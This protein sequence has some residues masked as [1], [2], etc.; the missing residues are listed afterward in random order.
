MAIDLSKITDTDLFACTGEDGTTYSVTGAQFKELFASPIPW[1]GHPGG[2]W[3]VKNARSGQNPDWDQLV[4]FY[5][6]PYQAYTVDGTD[7]GFISGFSTG[8]E[9]VFVAGADATGL[10]SGGSSYNGWQ[11]ETAA[12]DF[13]E[14][15]DTSNVTDMSFMFY[16]L[17]AF[18]GTL[19][20]NWDT[21]N[22]TNMKSMFY[23]AGIFNQDIDGWNTS[24]VTIM[25]DM[26]R[27]TT[28]FNRDIGGWNTSSVT[29]MCNMF[30]SAK[31]FNRDIGR[32][33]T[34]NVTNMSR[35]FFYAPRFNRDIGTKQVTV[36][37]TTYTAWNTSNVTDM[38][39]LFYDAE[40]FN[41]DIGGWDT[42]NVT[43]M[44]DMFRRSPKFDQDIGT[45]QVTVNG[46]TYTAWNTS[47]VWD[48][49]YMFIDAK[50]F[51]QDIGG[52][53]VSN[54]TDWS[55][56]FTNAKAFN[57]DLSGWCVTNF[58]SEPHRFS[59]R[60]FDWTEPKPC[61]GHCPRG[62]NNLGLDPCP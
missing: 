62:E 60:A 16:H 8:D 46:T 45:K 24:N 17:Q 61:W 20:G 59:E 28:Y 51:N 31:N 53:D 44:G 7:L 12:W 52:W 36:N 41:Q 39:H 32:W 37:G 55:L 25:A 2:I 38:D 10:F 58:T 33:D 3:H 18:N 6:G 42:S 34:S 35:M 30:Q 54:V 56:T 13:G 21:S 48:M 57:Q 23:E 4:N 29:N 15:T 43:I 49:G 27:Y 11:N 1:E 22:V 5:G 26:F 50:V 14:H 47:N 40:V 9:L 19:D